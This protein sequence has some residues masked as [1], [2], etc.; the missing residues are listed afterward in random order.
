MRLSQLH[1]EINKRK[2]MYYSISGASTTSRVLSG[3][4]ILLV[5]QNSYEVNDVVFCKVKDKYLIH[6]IKKMSNKGYLIGDR[7]HEYGW[8]KDVFAKIFKEA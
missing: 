1:K 8:T 7:R 3:E 5:H 4:T 6:P 2:K